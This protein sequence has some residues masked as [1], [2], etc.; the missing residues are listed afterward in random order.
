MNK[1]D[2]IQCMKLLGTAYNKEFDEEQIEVWYSMLYEYKLEDLTRAIK[3]L[4]KTETRLPSI[5]HITKQIAKTK[6]ATLPDA[7]TEWQ[8]VLKAVRGFGSYRE[9]EA[10]KSLKP[11]TAQI[12]KYI[13]YYRICVSTQDEQVWNKKEFIEEYNSLKDKT[14]ENLQIGTTERI[15]LNG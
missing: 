7:D 3:E 10:L 1:E 2:F 15:M 14:M 13:G 6:I 11:Y 9:E 4:I 8:E 12:V 5:A